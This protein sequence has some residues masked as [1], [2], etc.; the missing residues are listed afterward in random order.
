[1]TSSTRARPARTPR[2]RLKRDTIA[3]RWEPVLRAQRWHADASLAKGPLDAEQRFR[4]L[5]ALV[6]ATSFDEALDLSRISRS[7]ALAERARDALFALEW[8]RTT[9]TRLVELQARLI[10]KALLGLTPGLEKPSESSEKYIIALAQWIL[11]R[12]AQKNAQRQA[13]SYGQGH[14]AAPAQTLLLPAPGPDPAAQAA[15]IDALI[16]RAEARLAEAEAQ[17]AADGILPT[18]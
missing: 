6:T 12:P 3:L 1:M 2:L 10:D 15:E 7:A 18:G 5:A 17:L 8:D 9:D 14:A 13:Q 11:D 16:L 4:L